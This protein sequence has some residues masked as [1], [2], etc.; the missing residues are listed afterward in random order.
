M[1]CNPAIGGPAKGTLVRE[2]D[3]LGGQMGLVTDATRL[4]IKVLNASKGP[5]VQALRAQSDKTDYASAMREVVEATVTVLEAA[6]EDLVPGRMSGGVFQQLGGESG[7]V[8]PRDTALV[9]KTARGVL[10]ARCVVLTTGTFLGGKCFTGLCATPGGRHGEAASLGLTGALARLG[11]ETARLKT[12]TPPRVSRASIDFSKLEPAPGD[13]R[14]LRFSYLPGRF[15]RP[16]IPCHLTYT[17]AATHEI[18]RRN[19]HQSPMYGGLIEGVGPRY[20]PSIEDKV[21]R[22]AAKERHQLFIEPE[23]LSPDRYDW[24]YVQGF[25]TSLPADVQHE[26]VRSLPGLEQAVIHRPG[27]AVEYDYVPATQLSPT[28]EAKHVPGLFCAGQI[29]GTSGYEEAAAQGLAAGINAA[30]RARG[31]E[32]VVFPRNGSYLGTLIDDLVTKE[33]REPYRMLTSRSEWRLLLRSDNADLRLTELGR[34]LGLVDDARWAVFSARKAAIADAFGWLAQTRVGPSDRATEL[35]GACGETLEASTTLLE[36]LRRPRVNPDAIWMLGGRDPADPDVAE[37]VA[38]QVKYD[39]YIR[40]QEQEVARLQTM[41]ER[42]LPADL[43]YAAIDGLSNEAREK[44]SR[45]RPVSIGQASRIGGITPADV[46]LVL[47]HLEIRRR[48]PA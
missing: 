9:V 27:Y 36:L 28:L 6:V 5:A 21:M 33:I 18:I 15:E 42:R 35:L 32:P 23:G 17:T 41:E 22:F 26:M 16:N 20:C 44:L 7:S 39:G 25:S 34:R 40:R 29:N 3:A 10:T 38:T 30:L 13:D 43:D 45:V 48:T 37:Q 1:P 14:A 2:V 12:G 4:Q 11:F 47:V 46:S 19:L 31:D 8:S 24:M